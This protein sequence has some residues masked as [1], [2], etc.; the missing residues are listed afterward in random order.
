M[1][2]FLGAWNLEVL[3][4]FWVVVDLSNIFVCNNLD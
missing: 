4:H 1:N 2:W 3:G